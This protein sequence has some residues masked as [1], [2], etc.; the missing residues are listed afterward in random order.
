MLSSGVRLEHKCKLKLCELKIHWEVQSDMRMREENIE[1]IVRFGWEHR[2]PASQERNP[3]HCNPAN[4]L[5]S[6]NYYQ[7]T[8]WDLQCCPLATEM[9]HGL[10]SILQIGGWRTNPPEQI[11]WGT[12]SW[13]FTPKMWEGM[14]ICHIGTLQR[15]QEK[16]TVWNLSYPTQ[17]RKWVRFG[18][19]CPFS[20]PQTCSSNQNTFPHPP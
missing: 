2:P 11:N 15:K 10:G 9:Q 14:E 16:W 7:P 13:N 19:G 3:P 8:P 20:K 4:V 6:R 12:N 5:M 17:G 1:N 18:V